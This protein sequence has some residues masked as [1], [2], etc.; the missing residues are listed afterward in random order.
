M[1]VAGGHDRIDHGGDEGQGGWH[2]SSL[3]LAAG[4]Q[5]SELAC[6]DAEELLQLHFTPA[7]QTAQ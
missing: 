7:F 4:L 2:A 3:D 1:K 6:A 5:V